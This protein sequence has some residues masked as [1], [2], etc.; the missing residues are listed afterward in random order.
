MKKDELTKIYEQYYKELYLYAFSI[1]K[2]PNAAQD[3]VSDTFFKA[4][5]T[6]DKNTGSLKY[7]L[8]RVCRNNCMDYFRKKQKQYSC[9]IE[10][11]PLFVEGTPLEQILQNEAR[12]QL[13]IAISA[14]PS[15]YREMVLLYY[16]W[17][18]STEE[19]ASSL[20]LSGGAVRTLLYRARRKLRV[21]LEKED[22]L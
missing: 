19:I 21:F 10:E 11:L 3:M 1:C 15:S 12:Q 7:W 9:P 20:G 4:F 13:Y 22:Y 5:L 8:L 14:L 16:F 6:I 2:E 18:M 17:E